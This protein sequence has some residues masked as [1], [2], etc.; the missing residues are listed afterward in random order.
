MEHPCHKCNDPVEDG[1]AYCG[2]CGA[3]QIRVVVETRDASA[4]SEWQVSAGGATIPRPGHASINAVHSAT[5]VWSQAL[6]AAA[7]AGVIA[8]FGMALVGL[9]GVWMVAAGFLS[10][11]F[12]RRRTRGEI[13]RPG[14]GACLGALTGSLGF[15]TFALITVPTGFFRS[16]MLEL[17]H[18]LQQRS[19][20]A[21]QGL[22]Q[23]WLEV[24]KT[25]AGVT[26]WLIC[27]LLLSLAA[28]S[29]GGALGGAWL[30][31]RRT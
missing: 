18:Q 10:T 1:V 21:L 11:V 23:N 4:G 27:L 13:L 20:P 14:A 7:L 24:L 2:H 29:I 12:Y 25:P 8:G 31:R 19:D 5:I 26:V 22:A 30:G 16:M 17:V 9:F 28:A 3:P 15:A 6:P